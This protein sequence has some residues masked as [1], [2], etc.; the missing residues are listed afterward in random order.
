MHP[1]SSGFHYD[2]SKHDEFALIESQS[3]ITKSEAISNLK[4]NITIVSPS[5]WLKELSEKSLVFSGLNHCHI[6][7]AT[8]TNAFYY[9]PQDEARKILDIT[10]D[11]KIL[12]FVAD[13]I[14]D[15]R[16]GFTLFKDALNLIEKDK[17]LILLVGSQS[18]STL[19]SEIE[20]RELGFIKDS[21]VLAQI[22]SSADLFVMPSLEDNFPNTVIESLCCGTPVVSFK[23]RG[24]EAIEPNKNGILANDLTPNCL[25]QTITESMIINFNRERIA[26]DAS[27]KYDLAVQA[28]QY[29][30]VYIEMTN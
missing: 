3:M 4:Q 13:N 27:K 20:I 12:L 10:T 21:K 7:Y 15:K 16:K 11:K 28:S 6:P 5:K 2:H 8:D 9:I 18:G 24:S 1:F 29:L 17:S 22:Y 23:T 25:A 14:D 30:E 19:N 26:I